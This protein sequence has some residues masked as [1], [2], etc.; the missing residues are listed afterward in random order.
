MS[1][2]REACKLSGC[3]EYDQVL[4]WMRSCSD[5]LKKARRQL[6]ASK[7]AQLLAEKKARRFQAEL[8]LAV[9]ERGEEV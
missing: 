3:S 4:G 6:K 7:D 1:L 5:D 8:L 9:G 2:W